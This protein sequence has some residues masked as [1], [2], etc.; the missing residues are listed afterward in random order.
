[1]QVVVVK[2]RDATIF[3]DWS[4][5]AC[6]DESKCKV[7]LA[8]GMLFEENENTTKVALLCSEDAQTFS[9]W[10]AIPTSCIITCD[11]IKEIDWEK[12]NGK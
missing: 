12:P 10:I 9:N 1:M 5:R 3:H 6:V 8:I 4:S 7:C 2:F 11:V